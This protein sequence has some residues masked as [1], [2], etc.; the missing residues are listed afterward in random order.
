MLPPPFH[1][2]IMWSPFLHETENI[3]PSNLGEPPQLGTSKNS[4][5]ASALAEHEKHRSHS[6]ARNRKYNTQ[7]PSKRDAPKIT[8]L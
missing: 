3:L 1:G 2:Q 4:L 5:T 8:S 6:P 7:K